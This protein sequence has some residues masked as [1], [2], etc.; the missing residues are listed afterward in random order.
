MPRF[1]LLSWVLV[2]FVV[3]STLRQ[4]TKG[5]P[6]RVVVW[7]EQQP[8]QAEAYD[9]FLGNEIADY[10]KQFA[11]LS[12]VSKRLDD[13]E[14][15]IDK[16][17]LGACDVLI[18][19]GHARNGEVSIDES[20]QI[21]RRIKE[22]K[23]SMIALH[24]AHWA[25]PF[26]EAMNE[27]TR[28]DAARKYPNSPDF[29]RV[30]FD[31]VPPPGRF[32]PAHESIQTPAY[33]AWKRRGVV[34]HVRVDLPN[35]CFPDYRPDGKPGTL[36]TMLPD[37]PIAAGLPL[38]FPVHQTEMYNEPFHV[39]DPDAVL[40]K[41]TWEAGEWF[42]SGAVW[43]LGKGKV[44]YFRPG[45]EQSPVYKQKEVQQIIL[46]T[47]RWLGDSIQK[48]ADSAHKQAPKDQSRRLGVNVR[49][50]KAD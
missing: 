25:M 39:P 4:E 12:V 23:L 38:H 46:N 22:G 18:W 45:H 47:V 7:D 9:N 15:G 41:E 49:S 32:P 13:P 44:F 34:Q 5:A 43:E 27:R 21:V 16:A 36:H 17:T 40:F 8:R 6:I 50:Q 24:S 29:P 42:R 20:K 10:L 31:F 19:W 35:C 11:D 48:V 14:K 28:M 33:Y 26:M 1:K 3:I 37:H 30:R 2:L